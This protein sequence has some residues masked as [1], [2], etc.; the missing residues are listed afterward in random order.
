MA[1]LAFP[2]LKHHW[3]KLTAYLLLAVSP[4][5]WAELPRGYVIDDKNQIWQVEIA[6]DR[7]SRNYGLM[8]RFY[9]APWQGMLFLFPQAQ[10][11]AFWMKNT[12][13]ALDIRFYAPSGAA[14]ARYF[15][16]QP[17]LAEPCLTYPS[18]GSA[19]YVLE[20]RPNS[21]IS[22]N[23]RILWLPQAVAIR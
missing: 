15:N 5:A 4:L 12:R 2:I 17:C 16:A 3:H 8:N 1:H 21:W 23:I 14:L 18:A 10:E 11:R 20:T 19:A 7:Q 9:L 22:G 6:A 13:I